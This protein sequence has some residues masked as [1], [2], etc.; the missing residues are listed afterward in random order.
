M[1]RTKAIADSLESKGI[2]GIL[3]SHITNVRYVTGFTGSSGCVVITKKDN[4]FC[5]DF[6]YEEQAKQEIKGFEIFI[7]KAERPKEII[8]RAKALGI[9][10]LGFESTAS[11]HFYRSL[12]R[13]GIKIKAVGNFVE[14]LRKIK[15]ADE[16]AMIRKAIARAENA[17]LKTKEA[18]RPGFTE[19]QVALRLEENL[20]KEGCYSIPFDII[21]ASGQNSALPHAKPTEKKIK[22][23]DLVVVDWGGEAGGYFSDM[24]RS[25]LIQGRD[26]SRKKEIYD[27]VLQ[28]NIEAIHSV[29]AGQSSRMVDRAARDSIKKTGYSNFFGHGTG[30]GVGLDVHELPRISRL[31]RESVKPGMVFTIEPGVYV[32]G[33][34]GVRIED[35]VLVEHGGRRVLTTLPKGLEIIY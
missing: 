6:R 31:G 9:K 1:K 15:D 32:P 14:D 8:E 12:L 34:G 28:A 30:H 27:A 4:I 21:V 3:L 18:V 20:K 33:I 11:Y 10:T 13:K 35:M 5:T 23:G 17:F 16:L 19:R 29:A 24:T 26:I 25:F 2:D 22:P 7:E